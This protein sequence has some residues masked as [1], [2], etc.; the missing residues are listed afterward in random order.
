MAGSYRHITND[1]GSY[2]GVDLLDNLGD[3]D[4]ALEECVAMIQAM[5]VRIADIERELDAGQNEYWKRTAQG[6]VE[7]LKIREDRIAELERIL[8]SVVPC[9]RCGGLPP[10]W[11]E[12]GE[13]E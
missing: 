10:G 7:A 2:R 11:V 12:E 13:H 1:D 6:C 8:R 4:E 3:A 9:E 5:K